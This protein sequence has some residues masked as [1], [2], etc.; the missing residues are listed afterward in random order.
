MTH[1]RDSG[2]LGR[3]NGEGKRFHRQHVYTGNLVAYA[4]ILIPLGIHLFGLK[5]SPFHFTLSMI[6]NMVGN[7]LRFC[8]MGSGYRSFAGLQHHHPVPG[9]PLR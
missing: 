1:S 2:A 3:K 8:L 9:R 5:W 4:L 7:R 6:G